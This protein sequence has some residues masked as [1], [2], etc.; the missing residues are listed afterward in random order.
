M[1]QLAGF[2]LYMLDIDIFTSNAWKKMDAAEVV[3][4]ELQKNLRLAKFVMV[5][6]QR[7]KLSSSSLSF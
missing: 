6:L 2:R 4:R 7:W 5:S 1:N 3:L